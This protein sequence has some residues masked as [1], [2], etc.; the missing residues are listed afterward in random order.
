M[1]SGTRSAR[2]ERLPM[3]ADLLGVARKVARYD[4][5]TR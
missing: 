4:T 5:P 2:A 3:I 1:E